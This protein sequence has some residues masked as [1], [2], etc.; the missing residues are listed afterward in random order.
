MPGAHM[1]VRCLATDVALLLTAL[2]LALEAAEMPATEQLALIPQP[3]KVER[4]A[5]QFEL[6]AQTAIVARPGAQAEAERL[7]A[8]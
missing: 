1:T 7:A 5:G 8:A 4:A 6:T 2:S 3:A